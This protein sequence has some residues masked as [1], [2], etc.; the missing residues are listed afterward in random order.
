LAET[1]ENSADTLLGKDE[2]GHWW[3]VTIIAENDDGTVSCIVDDDDG[4]VW[5]VVHRANLRWEQSTSNRTVF[6]EIE[7]QPPTERWLYNPCNGQPFGIRENSDVGAKR[8]QY[9]L[10]PGE[11]IEVDATHTSADGVTHL[12]LADGRGWLFTKIPGGCEICFPVANDQMQT[13]YENDTVLLEAHEPPHAE[14]WSYNPCNG[15]PASIREDADVKAK[16]T[17]NLLQPGAAFEVDATQVDADGVTH[18]RF[19]DGRGWLFTKIPGGCSICFP[20]DGP[21]P[22]WW[23]YTPFNGKLVSVRESADVAAK[24]TSTTLQPG[25]VF[26]VDGTHLDEQ[27]ILHLQL[28]DGSGWLFDKTSGGV[29]CSLVD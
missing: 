11:V 20:V 13:S 2:T 25:D 21:Q 9:T 29:L 24:R 23:R 7:E 1:I 16:R 18:L 14:G 15:K 17:S 28:A 19:A 27:G 3:Q 6:P 12:Q 4:T 8:T 10:Q 22:Q 5:D 26:Q